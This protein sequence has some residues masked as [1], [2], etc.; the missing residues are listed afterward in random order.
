MNW[1][2]WGEVIKDIAKSGKI[3]LFDIVELKRAINPRIL[4]IKK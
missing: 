2:S 4:I 3:G 1:T